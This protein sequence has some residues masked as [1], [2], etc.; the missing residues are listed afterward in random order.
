MSIINFCIL[1]YVMVTQDTV[2]LILSLD[3]DYIMNYYVALQLCWASYY[4]DGTLRD[5]PASAICGLFKQDLTYF[6]KVHDARYF[7]NFT[8]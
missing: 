2:K 5:T 4:L 1:W 3:L 7:A 6:Q 8:T